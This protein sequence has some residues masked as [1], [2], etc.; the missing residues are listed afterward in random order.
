MSLLRVLMM[1]TLIF[2][3]PLWARDLRADQLLVVAGDRFPA[4][5]IAVEIV[6]DAFLGIPVRLS[7]GLMVKAIDRKTPK[8]Q[9]KQAFY[10]R[11]VGRTMTQ[12]KA[13]WSELI[14]TGRGFPPPALNDVNELKKALQDS[15][16]ALSYVNASEDSKGLKVLLKI[17]YP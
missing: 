11:V 3:A 1:G 17:E 6:K 13:Y 12:M 7:S 8:P 5:T 16:G 4:D 10:E 14:F 15:T 2:A 9:L